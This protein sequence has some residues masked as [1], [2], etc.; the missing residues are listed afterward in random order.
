MKLTNGE[1][2]EAYQQLVKLADVKLPVKNSFELARL[3]N[4]VKD[5][6]Q[7]IEEKRNELVKEHGTARGDGTIGIEI[8]TPAH[9][10]FIAELTEL[11][12]IEQD[13]VFQIVA[14]PSNVEVEP[15]ILIP[16]GKFVELEDSG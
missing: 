9:E 4:K 11:F 12:N 3:I 15:S 5:S 16:L 7:L 8:G 6:F 1:I 2:W 14:L 10:G 13:I